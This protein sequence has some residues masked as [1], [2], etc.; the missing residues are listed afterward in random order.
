MLI[1]SQ[2]HPVTVLL[3]RVGFNCTVSYINVVRFVKPGGPT[4]RLGWRLGFS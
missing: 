1:R 3:F 2:L 4:H